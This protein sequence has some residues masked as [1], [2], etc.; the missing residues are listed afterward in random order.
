MEGQETYYKPLRES[1]PSYMHSTLNEK[2]QG[3]EGF[4]TL[5]LVLKGNLETSSPTQGASPQMCK[6]KDQHLIAKEGQGNHY[7][8]YSFWFSTQ[9]LQNHGHHSLSTHM[10]V[11]EQVFKMLLSNSVKP[12]KSFIF[13]SL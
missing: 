8:S 2:K 13:F 1:L 9:Q 5:P 6:C 4:A 12:V 10:L 7:P 11:E 3:F